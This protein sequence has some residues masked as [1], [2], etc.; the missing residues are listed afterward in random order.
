[1]LRT[2]ANKEKINNFLFTLFGFQKTRNRTHLI[3]IVLIH[4]VAWCL[5]LLLPLLFYPIR[6]TNSRFFIYSEFLS[7]I[8]PIGLFYL[9]YYLLLPRYFERR[10]FSAY[11]SIVVGIVI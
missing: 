9:N 6:F 4:I 5:F 11:F 3:F 1:M 7:K 10:K 2:M 8:L